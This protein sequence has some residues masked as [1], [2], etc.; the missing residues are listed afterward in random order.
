MFRSNSTNKFSIFLTDFAFRFLCGAVCEFRQHRYLPPNHY[1]LDEYYASQRYKKIEL[2][3]RKG[4]KTNM[5]VARRKATGDA[6]DQ[7]P[8]CW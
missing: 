1:D 2:P 7:K 6:D 4:E 5:D 8:Y 3:R